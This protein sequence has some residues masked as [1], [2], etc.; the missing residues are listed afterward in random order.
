MKKVDLLVLRSFIG[1]FLMTFFVV[2]FIHVMQF[3]FVYIDDFVGK[4]LEWYIV[5]ELIFYLSANTIPLAMPLAVLL[6][7]IMTYG[8]LGEK[9]ELTALKSSGIGLLQFMRMIILASVVIGAFSLAFSNY[10]L[11]GANLKFYTTLLDITQQKPAL[12]IKEDVF[13]KDI[14]DYVIKID[15]KGDDNKTIQGV[16]I[17]SKSSRTGNDDILTAREGEMYTSKDQRYLVM[18]L[19]DGGKF[20]VLPPDN[21]NPDSKVH[22]RTYFSEMEKV[23]DLSDFK[24][25]RSNEEIYKDHYVMMN[26]EQLKTYI[27]SLEQDNKLMQDGLG[28]MIKPYFTLY[29]NPVEL[30][31][32]HIEKGTTDTSFAKF[33]ESEDK[34]VVYSRAIS[35]ARTIKDQIEAPFLI[36]ENNNERFIIRGKIELHRKFMLAVACIILL[37]IGAPFGAIIR[38]G[39]FGYPVLFS[40]IFYIFYF[41]LFKIGEGMAKEGVTSAFVG[42]WMSTFVMLPIGIFFTYKAL[43][44]SPI[45][46]Q[47]SYIQFFSKIFNFKKRSKAE[48]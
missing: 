20:E 28:K 45:L 10:V 37:F 30:N 23:M 19:K 15:S 9:Y 12:N 38:K 1:P 6:S 11:P 47:E 42:M 44:D 33:I 3:F 32:G 26:V 17:S 29:N 40:V 41:A 8:N 4:G 48:G 21:K 43:N 13:Y 24:M 7:S 14:A 36:R 35:F 34:E 18:K 2:V 27:D 5:A 31:T 16:Y 25:S 39:G 22:V 46:N